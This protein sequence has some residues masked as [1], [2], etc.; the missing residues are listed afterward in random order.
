MRGDLCTSICT[1][2]SY[3]GVQAC[4]CSHWQACRLV[5]MLLHFTGLYKTVVPLWQ[6]SLQNDAAD[7]AWST[8]LLV[9]DC[10]SCLTDE[11]W[12]VNVEWDVMLFDSYR[13]IRRRVVWLVGCWISVKVSLGLR[14]TVYQ[15]IILLLQPTEDVVVRLEAAQTLK[16]DIL[17]W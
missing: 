9:G 16:L 4:Q 11:L 12:T 13:I 15:C 10:I 6:C 8:V 2:L 1:L 7:S 17:Y 3:L 5:F 14:P